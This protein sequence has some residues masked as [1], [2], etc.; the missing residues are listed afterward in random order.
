MPTSPPHLVRAIA[1]AALVAATAA[2]AMP[3]TPV[4]V[5]SSTSP[6][7]KR[8]PKA[9]P[10]IPADTLTGLWAEFRATDP[11][12]GAATACYN[13]AWDIAQQGADLTITH[14]FKVAHGAGAQRADGEPTTVPPPE[15]LDAWPPGAGKVTGTRIASM[16]EPPGQPQASFELTYEAAT[17]RL[18]GTSNG[19][20]LVLVKLEKAAPCM[21]ARP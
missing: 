6:A 15:P 16:A 9:T 1:L 13:H 3:G 17:G 10:G 7:A 2:C 21:L 20:K 19:E 8:S 11:P 18:V 14:R 4:D 5:S 12:K